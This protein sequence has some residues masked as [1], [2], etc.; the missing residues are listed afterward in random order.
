MGPSVQPGD[1]GGRG[2]GLAAGKTQGRVSFP[3]R[4]QA[5]R[6][7]LRA[8]LKIAFWQMYSTICGRF[9]PNEGGVAGYVD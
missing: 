5:G 2:F 8:C 6:K 4:M 1:D 7:N 9:L 3:R